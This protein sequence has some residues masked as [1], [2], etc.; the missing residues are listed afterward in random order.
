MPVQQSAPASLERNKRLVR[1]FYEQ[2]VSTGDVARIPE[3]I[4]DDCVEIDGA[5]RVPSGIPGMTAHVAG[6]RGVYA[7][8]RIVVLRQIAEGDIVVTEISATGVHAGEWIG[9]APTGRQLTFT[10]VNVDRVEGG[11]IVE[12]GGA[13]NMLGP[14]LEAGALRVVGK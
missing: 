9:I 1:D 5:R 14:L 11:R 4:A 7:G 8:L 12:H 3:F 2:V 10:G 13:A 6:V